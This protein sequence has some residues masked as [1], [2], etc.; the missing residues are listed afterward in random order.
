MKSIGILFAFIAS[1]LYFFPFVFYIFPIANTKM[2]LGVMGLCAI[3]FKAFKSKLPVANNAIVLTSVL[4]FV[5]S[6]FALIS[7]VVNEKSD[8]TYVSYFV[9]MWVWLGAAYFLTIVIKFVHG[10]ISIP[11][12]L[13]YLIAVCA[14]QCLYAVLIMHFP[15]FDNLQ[16]SIVGSLGMAEVGAKTRAL[17]RIHGFSAALD[18]AGTRFAVIEM[19]ICYMLYNSPYKRWRKTALFLYA[20]CF[21]LIAVVGNMIARTT[22]VGVLVGLAYGL[23]ALLFSKDNMQRK[24]VSLMFLFFGVLAIFVAVLLYNNNQTYHENLRFAFEGFFSLWENGEWNT[25][26]NDIL[27]EM[28]RWPE[29]LHTWIIGDGYFN[30][31]VR[32]DPYYIGY[33]WKGF[34]MGSDVG[35]VRFIFYFGLVGLI[36]FS[37]FM[38]TVG[39]LCMNLS[40]R[41]RMMFFLAIVINFIIWFKVA[42]D[43]FLFFAP[44]L[45]ITVLVEKDAEDKIYIPTA[46]V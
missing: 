43:L 23:Y 44:F 46:K 36:V 26:S 15:F 28:Y 14:F 34:Y 31:P 8:Y 22:T 20:G 5:V 7:V 11:L 21:M 18:F 10:E 35:F 19:C 16:R 41:F 42:T 9:S 40:T 30:N 2:I 25:N 4:A 32:T 24:Q 38:I 27:V 37:I 39:R 6:F 33:Q 3:G 1:V 13:N 12:I 17:E 45:W 29:T